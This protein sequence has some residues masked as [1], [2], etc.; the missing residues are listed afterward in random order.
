MYADKNNKNISL[1]E[2]AI[3]ECCKQGCA[4]E[5]I[6]GDLEGPFRFAARFGLPEGDESKCNFKPK[7]RAGKVKFFSKVGDAVN[8]INS[9]G[10]IIGVLHSSCDYFKFYKGG[11]LVSSPSCSLDP[12]HAVALTGFGY[13]LSTD[14]VDVVHFWVVK[15]S[16]GED[17]G[18]KVFF[19]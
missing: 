12:D 7:V 14:L 4:K 9:T 16:W 13:G 11:I 2:S 3:Y 19:F 6:D 10:A 18:E 1:S 15:N 17:W 5:Q 8:H